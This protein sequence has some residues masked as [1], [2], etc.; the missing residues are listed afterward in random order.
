METLLRTN[1]HAVFEQ[2]SISQAEAEE[3]QAEKMLCIQIFNERG[4][5]DYQLGEKLHPIELMF[6]FAP[7]NAESR[8]GFP[9]FRQL[10]EAPRDSGGLDIP[11]SSATRS[12][13][14]FA[15]INRFDISPEIVSA[16]D[17]T[18][19]DKLASAKVVT[20]ENCEDWLMKARDLSRD[21]LRK[22]LG[23]TDREPGITTS[24]RLADMNAGELRGV[25]KALRKYIQELFI[26]NAEYKNAGEKILSTLNTMI[27]FE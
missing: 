18:K 26:K 22:E 27:D 1:P 19:L 5:R 6:D 3:A 12:I 2:A 15:F 21:D 4:R 8:Y 14:I 17:Y 23:E 11:Y 7:D 9:T 10:L 20:V 24:R 13:R 16:M 25:I